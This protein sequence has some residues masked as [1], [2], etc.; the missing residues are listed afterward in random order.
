MVDEGE[1][2]DGSRG[3]L[4]ALGRPQHQQEA[5]PAVIIAAKPIAMRMPWG[6]RRGTAAARAVREVRCPDVSGSTGW[7]GEPGVAAIR[8]T[9]LNVMIE[10]VIARR[11][12]S[13]PSRD[14]C[15]PGRETCRSSLRERS[16]AE[17]RAGRP[18]SRPPQPSRRGRS[19]G[20][21]AR[22]CG[23]RDPRPRPLRDARRGVEYRGAHGC[24]AFLALAELSAHPRRGVVATDAGAARSSGSS[25]VVQAPPSA[26][27]AHARKTL[28]AEPFVSGSGRPMDDDRAKLAVGFHRV[29]AHS[30]V[31]VTH[32]EL[33]ALAGDRAQ[34]FERRDGRGRAGEGS[35]SPTT[36]RLSS[37]GPSA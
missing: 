18:R 22:R 27:V 15:R 6:S 4:A 16:R 36:A 29:D 12:V 10:A 37:R 1:G 34:T 19:G 28:P 25:V 8:V 9:R 20:P 23:S 26:S 14:R 3:D 13:H 30:R 2:H 11:A 32:V 21:R 17:L 24:D 31:A 35:A 33:G 7:Y 5:T